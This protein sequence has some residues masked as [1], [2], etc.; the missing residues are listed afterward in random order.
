MLIFKFFANIFGYLK[1]VISMKRIF[2]RFL[3]KKLKHKRFRI[4]FERDL[5]YKILRKKG[6]KN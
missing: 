5:G 4:H 3:G 6:L 2:E 1:I